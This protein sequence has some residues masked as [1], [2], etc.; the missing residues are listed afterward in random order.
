MRPS[1]AA[2]IAGQ[3]ATRPSASLSPL[4]NIGSSTSEFRER[5]QPHID[6]EIFAPLRARGV[7][8]VHTDLKQAPGVDIAGDVDDPA[9][10]GRLRALQPKVVLSSNL[11]EHVNDPSRFARS[12]LP[13]GTGWPHPGNRAAVLSLPC[14]S[15]RHRLP[16]PVPDE[17]AAMFA[18]TRLVTRRGRPPTARMRRSSG[19]GVPER[20][21]VRCSR[22]ESPRGWPEEPPR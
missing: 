5:R 9:I 19:G 22:T 4:L 21:R 7:E 10:Q 11:L 18:D 13:G 14:G 16:P 2:W 1:E 12:C 3:L 15:D 8:I 6:R 17:L 20:L